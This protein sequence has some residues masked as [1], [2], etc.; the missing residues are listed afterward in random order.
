MKPAYNPYNDVNIIAQIADLKEVDYHNT[1]V[2]T[3]LVELLVE[4]GIIQRAELLHKTKELEIDL[5]L[6]LAYDTHPSA[7]SPKNVT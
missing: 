6:D 2:I 1:L 7:S 5:S 4:K 3:A